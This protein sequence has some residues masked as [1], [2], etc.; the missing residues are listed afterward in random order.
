M[1]KKTLILLIIVICFNL[2]GCWPVDDMKQ[3]YNQSVNFAK[4]FC[5]TLM[6]DDMELA[7]SY[8]HPSSAPNQD[9]F[10]SFVANLERTNE[11]EFA[12]GFEIKNTIFKQLGYYDASYGGSY[13]RFQFELLINSKTLN[14]YFVIVDNDIGYGIFYFGII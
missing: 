13:Y 6:N 3:G 12:S 2:V 14:I 1:M 11:I 9:R 7:K 4:E 5:V 10:E 8:L